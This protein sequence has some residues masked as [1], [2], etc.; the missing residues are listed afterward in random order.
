MHE[1]LVSISC[2]TFNHSLY[3]RTCLD[4][5]INQRTNFDYEILIHDDASNDGTREIIE[6]Y[7]LRHPNIKAICQSENQYSKG[8]RGIMARFNFPRAR[9]KY[10]AL[11]EGDD[12]WTDPTKLQKQVDF[13]EAN[14]D[15]VLCFHPVSIWMDNGEL[16]DDFIT[17]PPSTEL[18][19]A[20]IAKHGN[21]I[22]TPSILFRKI[23]DEFP[24]DLL[25]APVGDFCLQ[26]FLAERGKFK[27]LPD[28]MAVYR[29]GVGEWSSKESHTR[30]LRTAKTHLIIGSYFES[31]SNLPVA[32][33]FF[34]RVIRFFTLHAAAI[35][36]DDLAFLIKDCNYVPQLL[37]QV[38]GQMDKSN[39][40]IESLKNDQ[41]YRATT[42]ALI[43][44]VLRRITNK[45]LGRNTK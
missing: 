26:M 5:L 11:C 29:F 21:F 23:M 6:E 32:S 2:I 45:L 4:G 13:L 24:S 33:I 25:H 22:H 31:R 34:D 14:P 28:N 7:S 27:M 18:D 36:K 10:I 43:R 1:P 42:T 17:N 44:V 35:S 19:I 39:T 8:V 38:V 30:L 37:S 16:K 3:I 9:G 40:R 20:T 15:Y 41:V 12:Y